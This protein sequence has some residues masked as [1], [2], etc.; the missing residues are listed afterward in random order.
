VVVDVVR[1]L[2]EHRLPKLVVAVLQDTRRR[3]IRFVPVPVRKRQ[4]CQL[5]CAVA[6]P[7]RDH[8]AGGRPLS[9]TSPRRILAD[10]P[11]KP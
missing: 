2:V 10:H 8:H 4:G 9:L 6:W 5:T 3:P 1:R 11:V 7:R